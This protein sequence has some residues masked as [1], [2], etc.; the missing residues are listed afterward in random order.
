M[1]M[2]SKKPALNG[3]ARK[4]YLKCAEMLALDSKK[5]API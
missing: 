2:A 3:V 5:G 1:T 4:M